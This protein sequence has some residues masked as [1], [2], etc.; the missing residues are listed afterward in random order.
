[1]DPVGWF[2][3]LPPLCQC[4]VV[5]YEISSTLLVRTKTLL[6]SPISIRTRRLKRIRK[7]LRG[8]CRSTR[9]RMLSIFFSSQAHWNSR[10]R[11][12]CDSSLEHCEHAAVGKRLCI[13][14][15]EFRLQIIG[16]SVQNIG[17]FLYALGEV[18]WGL[19]RTIFLKREKSK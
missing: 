1:M 3:L 15:P 6:A 13:T 19:G 2:L 16:D 12:Q 11:E 17:T 9:K 14:Q 4:H 8:S 7:R 10:I 5:L 18:K